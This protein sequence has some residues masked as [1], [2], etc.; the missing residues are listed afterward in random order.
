VNPEGDLV[1][2]GRTLYGTT[3]YGGAGGNGTVFSF[4]LAPRIL[5][6]NVDGGDVVIHGSNAL[7]GDTCVV[8]RSA[9][10]AAPIS[11]WTPVATNVLSASSFTIVVPNEAGASFPQRFYALQVR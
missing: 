2:E 1:M 3:E 10:L 9:D 11:S 5:S 8:L 7:A 6:L 4:T